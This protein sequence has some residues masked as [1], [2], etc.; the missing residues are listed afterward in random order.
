MFWL[1]RLV[2]QGCG[3]GAE[4][5]LPAAAFAFEV[6]SAGGGPAGGGAGFAGDGGVEGGGAWVG[7]IGTELAQLAAQA[8]GKLELLVFEAVL[9]IAAF[10]KLADVGKVGQGVAKEWR[11]GGGSRERDSSGA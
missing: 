8:C 7:E 9:P 5:A 11:G 6:P 4:R 10:E 3:V 2:E 1:G